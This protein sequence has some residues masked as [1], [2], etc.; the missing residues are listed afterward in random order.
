MAWDTLE[1]PL[2]SSALSWAERSY[3]PIISLILL[4]PGRHQWKQRE[5]EIR[6]L[7]K[8]TLPLAKPNQKAADQGAWQA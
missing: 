5:K 7:E 4:P 8:Q 6:A 3:T 1:P 2:L